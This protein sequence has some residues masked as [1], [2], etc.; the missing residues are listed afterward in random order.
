MSAFKNLSAY[1]NMSAFKN[2]SAHKI[3]V[4]LAL[5]SC[6]VSTSVAQAQSSATEALFDDMA[7]GAAL[8]AVVSRGPPRSLYPDNVDCRDYSKVGH[9]IW[10]LRSKAD[11]DL[12]NWDGAFNI[13]GTIFPHTFVNKG[14]DLYDVLESKCEIYAY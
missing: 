12:G 1:K 6:L 3:P 7:G 5:G 2:L 4:F 9:N 11:L 8:Y 10:S 13:H 14:V